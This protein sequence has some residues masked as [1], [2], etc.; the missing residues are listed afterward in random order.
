M[1]KKLLFIL[2]IILT[3]HCFSQISFESGYYI[4]NS[5]QKIKC[6]IKNIDWKNNPTQFKYKLTKTSDA[7]EITIKSVKEFGI[8]NVSKYIRCSVNIDK[9]SEYL[10]KLSNDKEPLFNEEELFLK[11][12]IE[13][14][15]SLYHYSED[16]N[17]K[18][19]FYDT[20]NTNIKQ[21]IFKSYKNFENKIAYF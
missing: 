7:K 3:T 5:N 12:L 15:A 2:T 21:L 13:G 4:D 8:D 10:N 19:F 1:K 17:L 20:Q 16:G 11:V 6:L 14:E 9:S 18:R